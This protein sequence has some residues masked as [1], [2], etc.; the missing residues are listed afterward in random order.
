MKLYSVMLSGLLLI[1]GLNH[2]AR[3]DEP[4]SWTCSWSGDWGE[5]GSAERAPMQM[6]G[7][8]FAADGGWVMRATS[9]DGYGLSHIRGGC[10]DGDCSIEQKYAD[11]ELAEQ[12]YYFAMHDS[13]GPYK[14]GVKTFR[15]TGTW[16][17]E[18]EAETHH[19]VIALT[20]TCKPYTGEDI[21]LDMHKLI[22][23][24]DD[25]Y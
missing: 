9:H 14:N 2:P 7:I 5:K 23:W 11:G 18:E 12:S 13:D 4:D 16:G 25:H 8:L 1:G 10:G 24:D 19:G 6:T 22:G 3:A 20:A 21:Y 15:Y 17:S